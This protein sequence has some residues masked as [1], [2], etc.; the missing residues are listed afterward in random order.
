MRTKVLMVL[1]VALTCLLASSPSAA[2]LD[3]ATADWSVNSPHGLASDPPSDASILSLRNRL[4]GV[5]AYSGICSSRFAD[6]RHSGNLSLVVSATDGRHCFPAIIDETLA[7]FEL[8]ALNQNGMIPEI[9]DLNHNGNFELIVDA[10]LAGPC[11]WPV[12]FAWT[13]KGYSDVSREYKEYYEQKLASLKEEIAAHSGAEEA[14]APRP[15]RPPHLSRRC[16][17][18]RQHYS[19]TGLHL[20]RT[21][22]RLRRSTMRPRHLHHRLRLP[23]ASRSC[24][25]QSARKQKRQRLHASSGSQRMRV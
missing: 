23:P 18:F 13:G 22:P 24:T 7:G 16:L 15:G 6:L 2:P 8:Y 17:T 10:E 3:L 20:I 11:T 21:A 12:I 4:E 19:V 14:Q 9:L 5:D 1:C 25:M